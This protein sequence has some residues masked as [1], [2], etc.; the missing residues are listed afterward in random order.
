MLEKCD[1]QQE[2][3]ALLKSEMVS[4]PVG[5]TDNC[6]M[7]PNQYLTLKKPSA[8]KSLHLYLTAW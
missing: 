2:H 1:D 7:P 6:L 4:T 5:F 8:R 3:K